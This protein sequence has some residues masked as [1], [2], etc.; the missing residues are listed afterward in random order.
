MIHA[1]AN[2]RLSGKRAAPPPAAMALGRA[3]WVAP[4]LAELGFG[5]PVLARFVGGGTANQ[6]HENVRKAIAADETLY[7]VYGYAL[8]RRAHDE[9]CMYPHSLLC[10][11][12][13]E[14]VDPT[15]MPDG[16]L[17]VPDPDFTYKQRMALVS[18]TNLLDE[19]YAHLEDAI[20]EAFERGLLQSAEILPFGA[21][22][23]SEDKEAFERHMHP[24]APLR[25]I[26]KTFAHGVINAPIG[27]KTLAVPREAAKE[28]V[29]LLRQD[30]EDD[31]EDDE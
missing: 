2:S 25:K 21:D 13:G 30:L 16:C 9:L 18:T 12:D 6:C 29:E 5:V 15:A 26:V 24:N 8:Q 11:A 17:F 27:K 10:T 28:Y 7:G 1:A 14:L 31:I 22:P 3:Q 19:A 20:L 23:A 4:A